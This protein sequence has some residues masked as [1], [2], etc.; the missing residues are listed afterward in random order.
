MLRARAGRAQD[1][2][3]TQK[4][5]V[6]PQLLCLKASRRGSGRRP[7]RAQRWRR[8]GE[9]PH[10]QE[11]LGGSPGE[12]VV[13]GV[14]DVLPHALA[15]D[16][17][18]AEALVLVQGAPEHLVNGA[19]RLRAGG[20]D[21][22]VHAAIPPG[23]PQRLPC[24]VTPQLGSLWLSITPWRLSLPRARTLVPR[25]LWLLADRKEAV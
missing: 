6:A 3:S 20:V 16:A 10:L 22:Q 23:R 17:Q 9:G 18:G 24:G 12:Q 5:L 2:P 13:L 8:S 14:R 4:V 19:G 21:T 15:L 7:R 1:I 11:A 25:L